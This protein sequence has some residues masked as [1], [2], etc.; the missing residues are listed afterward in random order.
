M[1]TVSA[2][3]LAGL[4]LA[5][6]WI[7]PERGAGPVPPRPVGTEETTAA[8]AGADA[9]AAANRAADAGA[10]LEVVVRG[11]GGPVAAR[12]SLWRRGPDRAPGWW[13][14][15]PRPLAAIG[16][17]ESADVGGSTDED[18]LLRVASLPPGDYLVRAETEDGLAGDASLGLPV[19]GARLRV[20]IELEPCDHVLR[21]RAAWRDGR[22]FA[23]TIELADGRGFPAAADGSFLVGG[24]RAGFVWFEFLAP[25]EFRSPEF[26]VE[27]PLAEDLDLVVDADLATVSGR[28]LDGPGGGPVGGAAVFSENGRATTD[29]AGEF[30]VRVGPEDREVRVSAPGF[31]TL[32]T[33]LPASADRVELL[34]ARPASVRGRVLDAATGE[35]RAGVPVLALDGHDRRVAVTTSGADG[36]Y[37]VTGLPPGDLRVFARGAGVVSRE[38][39]DVAPDGC[40]PTRVLVEA[41]GEAVR[42]LLVVPAVRVEGRVV[43]AAG[44]PV[45]RA[46]VRAVPDFVPR[47]GEFRMFEEVPAGFEEGRVTAT[48]GRG[49]F[50]LE[51]LAAGMLWR[52]VA[53]G[54]DRR[55]AV[56][57]PVFLS[58]DSPPSP[59]IRIPEHGLLRVRVVGAKTD[60]PIAGARVR[61]TG[62]TWH[63]WLSMDDR[64]PEAVTDD[65]G[66]AELR[67]DAPEHGL[68]FAASRA[69]YP[70]LRF[71]ASPGPERAPGAVRT[72][73]LVAQDDAPTEAPAEPESEPG[74]RRPLDVRITDP[75]GRP[76]TSASV[77]VF[78]R[79]EDRLPWDD[80]DRSGEAALGVFRTTLHPDT[81]GVFVEVRSA[82]DGA[83]R[84]LG[85]ML[86]G[87]FTGP[88]A[89]IGVEL[90]PSRSVEGVFRGPDG[91]GVAGVRVLVLPDL[92]REIYV[93]ERESYAHDVAWSD[94][95][96][97]VR[98]RG[99]G[100]LPYRLVFSVPPDLVLPVPIELA[101]GKSAFAVDLRRA[102]TVEIRAVGPAGEPVAGAEVEICRGVRRPLTVETGADGRAVV[103]G[104]D[105]DV[106]YGLTVERPDG[107]DDLLPREFENRV[108]RPRDE[109]F[110]FRAGGVIRGRVV[111]AAG[112]PVAWARVRAHT[113]A[114]LAGGEVHADGEGRFLMPDLEAGEAVYLL[115]APDG[116]D[117]LRHPGSRAK[118]MPG[119]E[120]VVV[121]LPGTVGDLVLEVADAAGVS[122]RLESEPTGAPWHHGRVDEDGR[123]V[124]RSLPSDRTW[125]LWIESGDRYLHR[126]GLR[127]G[128]TVRA[129]LEPGLTVRGRVRFPEGATRRGLRLAR[130]ELSLFANIEPDGS[131]VVSP[132]PPGTWELRAW[133]H[134][135]GGRVRKVFD[136][137]AGETVDV[138]LTDGP[139]VPR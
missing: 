70:E 2:L 33:K 57:G 78:A 56:A 124:F 88:P 34:L 76:V 8:G 63:P 122:A 22:P 130:G 49:R 131:Y 37:R 110:A 89:A 103:S 68:H 102:R 67:T 95:E 50:A 53:Q 18:G 35:A 41:G 96:G 27:L 62:R 61:L 17:G 10:A 117:P 91:A 84:P 134:Y 92:P 81:T 119:D 47:V 13:I 15:R 9:G 60:L 127:A 66:R 46:V 44:E 1:R 115:A 45:A 135:P 38:L 86:A 77:R 19:A 129:S 52:F 43:D 93:G 123:L 126:T 85:A 116:E 108:W 23:G 80:R 125:S 128:D 7:V 40:D 83:G 133:A 11:P 59:T 55:Q 30:R 51:D 65:D 21:G 3:A 12:V 24:F 114:N 82:R 14:D 121:R 71:R 111:D 58:A 101:R 4:L 87:P 109:V 26:R 73:A 5:L 36:A 104:L 25:G 48:D 29:S 112:R 64:F 120:N 138:D 74:P 106:G 94:A 132:V 75:E 16:D 98:L 100:D 139:V 39:R 20:E 32:R 97:R 107:V 72:V 118:A 105:P 90:S 6:L 31:A 54:P 136:V 99:L 137:L 42:D 69:G 113:D 79:A 28:V